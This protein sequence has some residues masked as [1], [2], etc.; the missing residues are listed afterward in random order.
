MSL[1]S[2]YRRLARK[3]E[4]KAKAD[5]EA[6]ILAEVELPPAVKQNIDIFMP[7]RPDGQR[8]FLTLKSTKLPLNYKPPR[9]I[10]DRDNMR[11]AYL[12]SAV[13]EANRITRRKRK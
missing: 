2:L 9:A 10:Y 1:E 11:P 12:P 3:A 7:L 8:M 4:A 6:K 5:A 13:A